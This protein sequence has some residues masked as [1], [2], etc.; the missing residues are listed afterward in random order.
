MGL[1]LNKV[2]KIDNLLSLLQSAD[3]KAWE[4]KENYT[5]IRVVDKE[6]DLFEIT[7]T[8]KNK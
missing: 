2:E 7:F 4:I 3:Y 5:H 1:P 8:P 6:G